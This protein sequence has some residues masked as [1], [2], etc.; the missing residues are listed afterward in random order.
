[1]SR[2]P[3]QIQEKTRLQP[4]VDRVPSLHNDIFIGH[5]ESSVLVLHIFALAMAKNSSGFHICLL[6]QLDGLLYLEVGIESSRRL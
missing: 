6:H 2:M 4:S 3:V 5:M 1:M